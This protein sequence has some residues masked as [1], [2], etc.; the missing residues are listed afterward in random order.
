MKITIKIFLLFFFIS[1]SFNT[2]AQNT[3]PEVQWEKTYG[4]EYKEEAYQVIETRDYG[5][6]VCGYCKS[7]VKEEGDFWFFMLDSTG[8]VYWERKIGGVKQDIATCITQNPDYGFTVSG[9]TY[10][11]GKGRRDIWVYKTNSAGKGQYNK[12]YG[13][14]KKDGASSIITTTD[15]KNIVLGYTNSIGAGSLDFWVLALNQFGFL[16]WEKTYGGSDSDIGQCIIETNDKGYIMCGDT[17]SKGAGDWDIWVVKLKKDGNIEWQKTFGKKY[18]DKATTIV[19]TTD[20]GYVVCGSTVNKN[21]N[22][23]IYVIKIDA[24]GNLLWEKSFGGEFGEEANSIC[25]TQDG[26]YAVAGYTESKGAGFSDFW[27]LK[28]D[29]KGSL[30][31][32]KTLGGAEYDVANSII[33]VVDGG[34]V[35]C[36]GTFSKGAGDWDI[37]LVKLK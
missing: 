5:L 8:F 9:F 15:E 35:V 1:I 37:W 33:Q 24:K 14:L 16:M 7:F 2:I 10:S 28:L 3:A 36:G 12:T 26:G 23:D 32:D 6:A 13:S 30:V 34:L 21:T 4:S 11:K 31:W 20:G 29:E 18:S 17:K 25:Q 22:T 27:V 19:Q